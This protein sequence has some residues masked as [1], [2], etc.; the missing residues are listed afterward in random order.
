[1]ICGDWAISLFLSEWLGDRV[2][3][4]LENQRYNM[5][6]DKFVHFVMAYESY[7]QL[8]SST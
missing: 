1:M 4:F 7:N 8:R 5:L 6:E 3:L 2:V